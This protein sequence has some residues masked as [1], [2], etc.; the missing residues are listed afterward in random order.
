MDAEGK[1]KEK[2]EKRKEKREKRKEKT[3]MRIPCIWLSGMTGGGNKRHLF[4]KQ[5]K[6]NTER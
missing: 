2:R 3:L 4:P 6:T 1:R 5:S